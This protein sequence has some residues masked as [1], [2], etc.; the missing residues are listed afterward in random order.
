MPVP[1]KTTY[2]SRLMNSGKVQVLRHNRYYPN[3]THVTKF[4]TFAQADAHIER[5]VAED[6][7]NRC[8]WVLR[9][10]VERSERP[11]PVKVD[12]GQKSLLT[13]LDLVW[14]DE[15]GKWVRRA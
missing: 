3:G 14:D 15:D 12:D 10:L 4:A 7:L 11:A 13:D 8:T 9:Y 5:Q 6:R 2:S 1:V